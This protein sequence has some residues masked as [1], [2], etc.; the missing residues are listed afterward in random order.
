MHI[1]KKKILVR[2]D[3]AWAGLKL[4]Q[5]HF[6]KQHDV[7]W[8]HRKSIVVHSLFPLVFK[9]DFLTPYYLQFSYCGGHFMWGKKI[10]M[11]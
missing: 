2:P 11:A 9:L 7:S 5:S 4:D 3:I 6:P 8:F 1:K 10:C